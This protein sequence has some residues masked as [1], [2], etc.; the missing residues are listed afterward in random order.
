MAFPYQRLQ[1]L[2]LLTLRC[3]EEQDGKAIAA[4][5]EFEH[6]P[7]AL[8]QLVVQDVRDLEYFEGK[9]QKLE[10][11]CSQWMAILSVDWYSS[12]VGT[13]LALDFQNDPSG[14]TA[15][16]TLRAAFGVKSPAT[17]LKRAATMKQYF[18]W[19]AKEYGISFSAVMPVREEHVWAY[20][21]WLRSVG[22]KSNRGFATPMSFLETIRFCKTE[23]VLESKRLLGFAAVEKRQKGPTVQAPP[24]ELEHLQKLHEVVQHGQNKIDRL[25]A[26]VMLICI[27]SRAR[28]SDIRYVAKVEVERKRNG[29]LIIYTQEH[30]TSSV[31][32]RREQY[33]PLIVPWH[34]VVSHDWLSAFIELYEECGLDLKKEPL[35]PLLHAPRVG[36]GFCAR[37]LTTQEASKWLRLLLDGTACHDSYRS[38]SLKCTLLVWCARAGLDREVRAVLGHHCSAL[39]GSEVVY[40]RHLPRAIRKLQMV[41][42]RIRVGLGLEEDLGGPEEFQRLSAGMSGKKSGTNAFLVSD[43]RGWFQDHA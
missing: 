11:A 36:G 20:F 42:H 8:Y 27:Y 34:G 2:S 14:D 25:G 40:S 33:L 3:L 35:G 13:R 18:K 1:R 21:H 4:V 39:H 24:L 22:K 12:T 29:C 7:S 23:L 6:S 16:E 9:N 19:Y 26:A 28:W 15:S 17:L 5:L 38:H 43:F 32:S 37:P 41:L 10:L 31:G 30:K